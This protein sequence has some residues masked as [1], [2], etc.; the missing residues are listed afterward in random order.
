MMGLRGCAILLLFLVEFICYAADVPEASA[1]EPETLSC[2]DVDGSDEE[3][4]WGELGRGDGETRLDEWFDERIKESEAATKISRA[5]RC[6]ELRKKLQKATHIDPPA[7]AD[8]RLGCSYLKVKIPVRSAEEQAEL[9]AAFESGEEVSG[10]EVD[11]ETMG[12]IDTLIAGT[13]SRFLFGDGAQVQAHNWFA[14][15]TGEPRIEE[16]DTAPEATLEVMARFAEPSATEDVAPVPAPETRPQ[17]VSRKRGIASGERWAEG[18][19]RRRLLST[20]ERWTR[21]ATRR[22]PPSE[23]M[24]TI[25]D[26][27]DESPPELGAVE[28]ASRPRLRSCRTSFQQLS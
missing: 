28:L 15:W 4:V 1:K 25:F 7:S 2:E 13:V 10:Q 24:T 27:L 8:P 11:V 19:T 12:Q 14:T 9:C 16:L 22:W 17:E 20:D 3:G 18:F 23:E 5:F 21:R 6:Y 26:S